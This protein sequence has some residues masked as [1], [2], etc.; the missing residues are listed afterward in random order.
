M[1]TQNY[2]LGQQDFAEIR[3]S[4]KVYID[5]TAYVYQMTHSNKFYFFSRPR[6]FGKTLLLSTLEYYFLGRKDLFQGF[7]FLHYPQYRKVEN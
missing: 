4:G 3:S 2:P 5:K 7:L 6:R 1:M